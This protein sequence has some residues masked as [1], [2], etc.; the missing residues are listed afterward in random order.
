MIDYERLDEM[1]I[2]TFIVNA[3]DGQY[4]LIFWQNGPSGNRIQCEMSIGREDL[5]NGLYKAVRSDPTDS[6]ASFVASE[7]L[8]FC[9]LDE[10]FVAKTGVEDINKFR[11]IFKSPNTAYYK[12]KRGA[13]RK[14]V[15]GEDSEIEFRVGKIRFE[16]PVY[17]ISQTG[18][19][20]TF[21]ASKMNLLEIGDTIRAS[22]LLSTSLKGGMVSA[23]IMRF[24]KLDSTTYLVGTQFIKTG[25]EGSRVGRLED[26]AYQVMESL[27]EEI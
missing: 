16:R 10:G 13:A 6:F 19:A 4:Q 8:Y 12:E 24:Q 23:K 25:A 5:D 11:L 2:E 27:F 1:K 17:D 26:A 9:S 20:F 3:I 14:R 15:T 7:P 21:P 18:M 22:K